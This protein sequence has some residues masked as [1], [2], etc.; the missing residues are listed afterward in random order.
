MAPS[1]GRGALGFISHPFGLLDSRVKRN[2]KVSFQIFQSFLFFQ[3]H[4]P[5]LIFNTFCT[6]L[7]PICF[8]LNSFKFNRIWI[9]FN[10]FEFNS[11][12]VACNV[13]RHFHLS[14]IWFPQNQF[15]ISI[16]GSSL[17]VC[18]FVS[19]IRHYWG[20]WKPYD[21]TIWTF[22]SS[23]INVCCLYF[24]RVRWNVAMLS[25]KSITKLFPCKL[26]ILWFAR[27]N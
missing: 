25:H 5:E 24:S 27:R 6:D 1:L 23:H 20:I 18:M 4:S 8:E 9:S 22:H 14:G 21:E 13:I 10:L 19:Y 2:E 7:P 12:Q 17:V 15:I 26:I 11:I 3:D 16:N